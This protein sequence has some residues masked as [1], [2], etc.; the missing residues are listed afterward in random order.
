MDR[1]GLDPILREA[2]EADVPE[3]TRVMTRAFDDDA[4]RHL[5]RDRGGPAGYDDGGFFRTWLFG[6]EE[7]EGFVVSC[8]GTI[9]GGV[10]VW[11]LPD[12]HDVLGTIF[13]D[14]SV[15]DRGVG[16]RVWRAIEARYP[17]ARSWRLTTPAWATKN[18]AFYETKCG[19]ER[20]ADDPLLAS[21]EGEVVYRK[22]LRGGDPTTPRARGG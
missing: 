14:P 20:V 8:D 19:F 1:L 11:I 2:T 9:V 22:V 21:P 5:G 3:L 15:Q 4:R 6:Y 16:T 18:H 7:T 10:I 12:G 17:A 13:V